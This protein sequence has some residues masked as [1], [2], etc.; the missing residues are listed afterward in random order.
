MRSIGR[1]RC[2][3]Y[4]RLG[5]RRRQPRSRQGRLRRGRHR[6]AEEAAAS[7]QGAPRLLG[8]LR[9]K[10]RESRAAKAGVYPAVT[11]TRARLEQAVLPRL[12]LRLRLREELE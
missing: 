8:L 6:S 11:S 5:P 3:L 10:R 7:A 1:R 9:R 2:A 4:A 12:L